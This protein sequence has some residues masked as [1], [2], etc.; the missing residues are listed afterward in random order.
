MSMPHSKVLPDN[1]FR[2][3]NTLVDMLIYRHLFEFT[4][5][6]GFL[7]Y[8]TYIVEFNKDL[9]IE[10]ISQPFCIVNCSSHG[11]NFPCGFQINN[12]NN[13]TINMGID[14][15]SAYDIE[16]DISKLHFTNKDDEEFNEQCL[17]LS[18]ESSL[19]TEQKFNEIYK[20]YLTE[21]LPK[22]LQK[23]IYDLLESPKQ[24]K[25]LL[26]EIF[27]NDPHL[28]NIVDSGLFESLD[29][30]SHLSGDNKYYDK[31]LKY[32]KKYLKLKNIK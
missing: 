3:K 11:I 30:E 20:K 29:L 6:S 32:K 22:D 7:I 8:Q 26:Y 13:F 24:S 12:E 16:L 10:Q 17:Y 2:H 23:N 19:T 1:P 27:K 31:Y 18:S 5:C 15:N 21:D 28:K 25:Q 4:H 9:N 14:D